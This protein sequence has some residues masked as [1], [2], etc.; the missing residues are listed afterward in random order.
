MTPLCAHFGVCG[1]CAF[2]DLPDDECRALKHR[3]VCNALG[4]VGLD[5]SCVDLPRAVS[6]GSR[7]RATL[8]VTLRDG[9][10]QIGFRARRS[11]AVTDLRECHVLT[12]A[13]VSLVQSFRD[14]VPSLLGEGEDSELRITETESGADLD[15]AFP[16]RSTSDITALLARWTAR[17]NVARVTVN[18]R[19]VVQLA[20]P[21]VKLAGVTV[22][23]PERAFLQPTCEGE[24]ILQVH[25]RDAVGSAKRVVDL[26]AGCGTFTLAV[27][28]TASVHAADSDATA[29]AALAA[30]ARHASGLKPVTTEVRDLFRLPLQAREFDRFD[31][32]VLD[33]PRAGALAQAKNLAG[34]RI[35][36]ICYVSCDPQSFARDARALADSGFELGWVRPVDQFVWSSHIELVALF[37]RG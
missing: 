18:G 26:F 36:R 27:A 15:A 13:L 30:A 2:Q 28:R 32:A 12:P 4:Q 17:E 19:V 5:A 24:D 34:S 21:Q 8:A 14:I 22:A 35:G 11:H 37:E 7:R 33:P 1:G 3:A 9:A 10:A 25:V 20:T 23:L 16:R 31:A 29:L 6:P